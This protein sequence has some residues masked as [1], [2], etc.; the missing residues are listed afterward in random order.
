MTDIATEAEL[1]DG[2]GTTEE[3]VV[4]DETKGEE[5]TKDEATEETQDAK[6]EEETKDE[7]PSSVEET[8]E[9]TVP[10]S[11]MHGERD[12]RQAAEKENVALKEKLEESNKTEPTSVFEDESKF[13][14]ELATDFNQQ[15]TNHSLNQSEFFAARELGRDVLDQKIEAFKKLAEDNPE[16]RQR[17]AI[18]V[19]PYHELVDIVNQHDELDKMKDL[20]GYKAKLKAEAKVEVKKE[21]EKEIEEKE[22]L[23][24]SIPDSLVGDDSAGGISS[25]GTFEKPTAEEL[26]N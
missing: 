20:D 24:K 25:K 7:S 16:L 23:R 21:L 8:K 15:L 9:T 13:R 1:Y 12:R 3:I 26:Y 2:K 4:V 14:N 11:A 5:E 10:I 17:F 18:A 22:K 6:K 19:S